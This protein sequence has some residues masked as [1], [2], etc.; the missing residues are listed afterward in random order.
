[1][2]GVWG[3]N[4]VLET[5][6]RARRGIERTRRANAPLLS[7]FVSCLLKPVGRSCQA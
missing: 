4:D 7:P 2:A 6:R 3:K 5:V 1:M